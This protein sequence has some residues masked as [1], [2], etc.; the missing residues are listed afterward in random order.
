M[1]AV[2]PVDLD[3]YPID[4]LERADAADLV[5][6]CRAQ[7]AVDGVC[8]LPGFLTAEAVARTAA[9]VE[10]EVP[11][12]Y[13]RERPIVALDEAETDPSIP[14]DDPIRTAHRHS[15]R[16]IAYDLIEQSSP[17]RL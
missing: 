7:L 9:A 5:R 2:L 6:R 14:A 4:D 11:H 3:R 17:I 12:A 1:A 16:T 15:M 10:A 13:G 8:L